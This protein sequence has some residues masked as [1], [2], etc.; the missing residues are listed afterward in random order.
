MSAQVDH[1][2]V[3]ADSLAQGAAWCE[4]TLGILPG[5][6]GHHAL[7]GTHNRVFAIASAV[8]PRAYF[9]IIAID[10]EAPAPVRRRWFGMDEPALQAAVRTSPRLLHF[11]ASAPDVRAACA[12]L[13]TCGE[14]VGSAAAAARGDLRW[15]ITLRDDGM[16]Q[17]AGA[18]PTLIEWGSAH[19]S[20]ALPASGVSLL[21]L[22]V[23]TPEPAPLQ[24]AYAALGLQGVRIEH[25]PFLA[26]PRLRA[27]LQTPRG[28]LVLDGG[29]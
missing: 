12:A 15:Q 5:P 22:D 11:V 19:P 13:T 6:G 17:H 2:V 4:A 3:V 7:M 14:D 1:L 18:L 21:A 26:R 23:Q 24:R 10:P 29:A 20:D 25:A 8:F 16:P 28:T 27:T 9:E